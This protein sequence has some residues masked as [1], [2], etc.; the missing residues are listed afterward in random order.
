MQRVCH[1]VAS[2]FSGDAALPPVGTDSLAPPAPAES[3]SLANSDGASNV[4][5]AHST[6]VLVPADVPQW[7]TTL[8]V[9]DENRR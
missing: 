2:A 7:G 8:F 5:L 9:A 1:G 3:A 6:V 4:I